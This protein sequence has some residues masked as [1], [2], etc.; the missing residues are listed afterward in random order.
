M[1]YI[2]SIFSDN[3][4]KSEKRHNMAE[5]SEVKKLILSLL[6]KKKWVSSKELLDETKQKYFDRRIRELRDENGYDIINK[7]INGEAHYSL[8]SKKRLPTIKRTYLSK[9]DRDILNTTEID[10]CP[11]CGNNFSDKRQKV[12]DHRIPVIKGGQGILD[13]YQIICNECNNQKRSIC[14][15]CVLDCNNCFLAFPEKFSAPIIL[16]LDTEK[17][18]LI[19]TIANKNNLSVNEFLLKIINEYIS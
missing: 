19:K 8:Q 2:S 13:N 7:I 10:I 9:K 14:R 17:Y 15:H 16:Q 12:Y 4:K 5:L 1:R 3:Y 18:N 11:I 6:S